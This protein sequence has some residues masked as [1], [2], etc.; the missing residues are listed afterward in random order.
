MPAVMEAID[1]MSSSTRR[2]IPADLR[3]IAPLGKMTSSGFKALGAGG[4]KPSAAM[5]FHL[6]EMT[7]PR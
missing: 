1:R 4:Q 2:K 3:G 7:M 5:P 6:T